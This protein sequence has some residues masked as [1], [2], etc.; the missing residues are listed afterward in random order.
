[1]VASSPRKKAVWDWLSLEITEL[2]FGNWSSQAG[3]KR[4]DESLALHELLATECSVRE[5]GQSVKLIVLIILIEYDYQVVSNGGTKL[6]GTGSG[7]VLPCGGG[8]RRG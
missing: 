2:R 3:T 8:F 1:M 6:H 4:R 5:R 7:I